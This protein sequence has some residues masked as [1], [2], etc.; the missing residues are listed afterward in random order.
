MI[1]SSPRIAVC[2]RRFAALVFAACVLGAPM[3]VA[4]CNT[5]EGAG[6]DVKSLGKGIEETAK[7]AKN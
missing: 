7:D 4:G 2:V 5:T 6:K 3:V 1:T